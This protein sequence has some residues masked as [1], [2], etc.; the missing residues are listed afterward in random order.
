MAELERIP[1]LPSPVIRAMRAEW[2][3][4]KKKKALRVSKRLRLFHSRRKNGN[5][6]GDLAYSVPTDVGSLETFHMFF[7]NLS[8]TTYFPGLTFLS[9]YYMS[10]SRIGG[11]NW[12]TDSQKTGNKM[13]NIIVPLQEMTVDDGHLLVKENAE[14]V[15]RQYALG[16]ALINYDKTIH[17]SEP[18]KSRATR[19]FA[20]FMCGDVS[21]T[22]S[23]QRAAI[24]CV[25]DTCPVYKNN[26]GI[27]CES[28]IYFYDSDE[29]HVL[30]GKP[31]TIFD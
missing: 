24:N 31:N 8:L 28:D 2:D 7:D 10:R 13:R 15:R 27:V 16:E 26:D 4:L 3:A 22:K 23:E 6:S 29:E 17:S 30:P 14:V 19:T 12:H 9:A 1:D 20:V 5:G 11:T 25:K 18:H 21:M